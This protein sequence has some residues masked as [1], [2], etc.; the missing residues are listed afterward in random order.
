MTPRF[1][2]TGL[3]VVAAVVVLLAGAVGTFLGLGA[4]MLYTGFGL[5]P[6]AKRIS[7]DLGAWL[8]GGTGVGVALLW[9]AAMLKCSAEWAAITVGRVRGVVGTGA[10]FGLLAGIASSLVLHLGLQIAVGDFRIDEILLGLGC[11]IAA[12]LLVGIVAGLLW[13]AALPKVAPPEA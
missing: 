13:L 9:S 6:E 10:F 4:V 8:G 12:G 2:R 11:G 3:Y 5:Q 7:A 1:K